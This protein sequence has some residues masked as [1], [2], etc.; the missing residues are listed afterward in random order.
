MDPAYEQCTLQPIPSA[1]D[2]FWFNAC[3][4]AVGGVVLGLTA[5]A[6]ILC[7]QPLFVEAAYPHPPSPPPT[8]AAPFTLWSDE[9]SRATRSILLISGGQALLIALITAICLLRKRQRA[10]A[11]KQP[12]EPRRRTKKSRRMLERE[13]PAPHPP[14]GGLAAAEPGESARDDLLH[15]A[16]QAGEGQGAEEDEEGTA[17]HAASARAAAAGVASDGAMTGPGTSTD[18]GSPRS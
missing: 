8:P 3:R 9:D 14:G 17:S 2:R 13:P 10:G 11:A 4:T 6:A 7:A 15:L 1:A 16:A 12:R 18:G 5:A